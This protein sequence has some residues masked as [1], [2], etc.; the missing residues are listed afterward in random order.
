[1]V[2]PG[3]FSP[4]P[5]TSRATST[6]IFGGARIAFSQDPNAYLPAVFTRWEGM[7]MM[8]YSPLIYAFEQEN[9]AVTGEG[10]LDG[11]RTKRTGGR[12][13]APTRANALFPIGSRARAAVRDGGGWCRGVAGVFN[14][15]RTCGRSSFSRIAAATS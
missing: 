2:P 14:D 6:S 3:L 5:F 12:G 11:Q 4:A 15:G 7:E 1:M 8:G 13:R 9:I 10:T